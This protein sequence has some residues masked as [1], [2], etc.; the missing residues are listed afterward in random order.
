MSQV[1]L[2]GGMALVFGIVIVVL[3]LS[4]RQRCPRCEVSLP[5]SARQC[6]HCGQVLGLEQPQ[7]EATGPP[8]YCPECRG[9]FRHDI[10]TCPNCEAPL[11][12]QLPAKTSGPEPPLYRGEPR[13]LC[14]ATTPEEA[15]FLISLL[16]EH[17]IPA[18][19]VESQPRDL[20]LP[21]V[22]VGAGDIEVGEMDVPRAKLILEEL[23]K[24]SAIL[25]EESECGEDDEGFVCDTC[26]A[27][28]GPR[29]QACPQCGA[30]FEEEE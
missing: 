24:D 1:Y 23:E 7:I 14:L 21:L 25:P 10:V 4:A 30:E 17:N 13:I 15:D 12:D 28:V 11:Q 29:D 5:R 2:I 16:A 26:G 22:T 19:L 3:M 27:E 9:E 8:R 6:P 18:A 20:E